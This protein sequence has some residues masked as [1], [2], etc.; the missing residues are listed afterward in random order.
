MRKRVQDGLM[1]AGMLLALVWIWPNVEAE[2]T[3]PTAISETTQRPTRERAPLP[4]RMV[5]DEYAVAHAE[6][7]V[8]VAEGLSIP[9][10]TSRENTVLVTFRLRED[11][12]SIPAQAVIYSPECG[13]RFRVSE[14]T[15]TLPLKPGT[16]TFVGMRPSGL[17][18]HQTELIR[19]QLR[20]GEEWD[21]EL[22]FPPGE[23]GGLGATLMRAPR[24]VRLSSVLPGAAAD[25]AGLMPGD[26]IATVEGQDV[27]RM[28]LDA[29]VRALTGPVGSLVDVEIWP[30]DELEGGLMGATVERVVLEE[31]EDQPVVD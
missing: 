24:G 19:T 14:G 1:A 21:F 13:G 22:T 29:I 8:A 28:K 12:G 6:A 18:L 11:D 4:T 25:R 9:A 23:T 10:S 3:Q 20:L 5:P 30:G 31:R 27:T 7:Q 15:L 2:P 17:L 16:C 26:V